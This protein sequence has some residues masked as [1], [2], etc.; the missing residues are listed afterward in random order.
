RCEPSARQASPTVL[1]RVV[2]AAGPC[3]AA[4]VLAGPGEARRLVVRVI[5]D[6]VGR[7]GSGWNFKGDPAGR[8]ATGGKLGLGQRR[9]NR[10]LDGAELLAVRHL[11][12]PVGWRGVGG[13]GA[14]TRFDLDGDVAEPGR[15]LVVRDLAGDPIVV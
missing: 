13:P 3:H 6:D 11:Q 4:G 9:A 15:R 1:S 5:V 12:A 10:Q 14:G 8:A 7:V 2:Q